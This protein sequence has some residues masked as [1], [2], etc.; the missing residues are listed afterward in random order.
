[1][2]EKPVLTYAQMSISYFNLLFIYTITLGKHSIALLFSS[3]FD[4]FF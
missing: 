2:L 3:T 1:L 4:V